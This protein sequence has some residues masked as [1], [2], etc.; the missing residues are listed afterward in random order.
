MI[1]EGVVAA[2]CASIALSAP[3]PVLNTMPGKSIPKYVDQLVIPPVY[4]PTDVRDAITGAVIRQDYTIDMTE[5]NQQVLPLPFPTT[6]VW[7]YGGLVLTTAGPT[8]LRNSPGPTLEASKNL[9][10]NVRW[11]NKI[12]SAYQF[13]VDP[14]LHW[15]D[16]LNLGH[17]AAPFPLFPPGFPLAQSTVPLIPHLHGGEVQSTSDGHPE[18]WFTATGI[19][20]MGFNS[21]P[22]NLP[23]EAIFNYPNQQPATTLWYHDHALGATRLNVMSGLAGFY[24]LRDSADPIG[25]ILPKGNYEVP[26][27]IQDRAFNLDGSLWF[28]SVGLNLNV[29]PYWMPE[30]FGDAIMVNGKTWPNL[31][32][33]PTTYRFRVLNG[34]NA[35]FYNLAF[36]NGMSFQQVGS[37]GGYLAAPAILKQLLLA[38]GE[39]ADIIVDFS[40]V[41]P[42]TKLILTNDAKAPFPNGAP[43]DPQSVGQILQFTLVAATASTPAPVVLPA[44][45]AAIP[46]LTPSVPKRIVTLNE[47]MGPAGPL[48]ILLNGQKWMSPVSELPRV[49]SVE[50]WEIVNMT[51]DTHPIH[52]HLVQFQVI[53]RQPFQV[54]KYTTD[55]TVLNGMAPLMMPTVPLD[56]LA[57]LQGAA[58][59]PAANEIGWKDT[60][61]APKG[62]V[63]R[64][65]VRYAPQEAN[66]TLVTPGANLFPFDPTVGPGYVWHCHIL[67]HEDNEMMRPMVVVK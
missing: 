51:A 62:E 17:P 64:I 63:T 48:E 39:R 36:S 66:P 32:V 23:G 38:P 12:T 9:P 41:A 54:K 20:G 40:K 29:H 43:A 24:L 65:R 8:Y 46:A 52:L 13:A 18:A 37:D 10:L 14:T 28:P 61:K 49:G 60:V 3:P 6:K 45:L 15:A 26:V 57:Y 22:G 4:A 50:D 35:R 2:F 30:F 31:N 55:W 53:N 59:A 19:T 67:D 58:N 34:S 42:G 7:G 33:E 56:P 5:F 44:T 11:Q 25:A 47:V 27:V 21:L 16:P 1:R